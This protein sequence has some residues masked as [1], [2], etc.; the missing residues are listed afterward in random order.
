MVSA[1]GGVTAKCKDEGLARADLAASGPG[2]RSRRNLMEGAQATQK[3]MITQ[4]GEVERLSTEQ[5][6]V[7]CNQLIIS[8]YL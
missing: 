5:K 4:S 7:L 3:K 6:L 2:T 8:M 1:W